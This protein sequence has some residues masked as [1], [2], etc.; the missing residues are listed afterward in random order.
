MKKIAEGQTA[1]FPLCSAF[2]RSGPL[3]VLGCPWEAPN[4][5]ETGPFVVAFSPSYRE[6]EHPFAKFFHMTSLELYPGK[7]QA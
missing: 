5:R 6:K 2:G 4:H 1:G 7:F 3:F